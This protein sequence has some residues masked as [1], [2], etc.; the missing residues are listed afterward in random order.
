MA[1]DMIRIL[2]TGASG[3]IGA[4]LKQLLPEL[5]NLIAPDRNALDLTD[6]SALRSSI[7]K[8][9]PDLI[10]NAAAYTAVDR[11]EDEQEVARAVNAAAPAV[12][13]EEARAV[14]AAVVHYSTDYVFD[15]EK[16]GPYNESDVPR[17]LSTYGSSK[18]AGE[19]AIIAAGIPHLILRTSWIY[20]A[21]GVN[22]MRT[23]LRLA[24]E[25]EELRVVGDQFGAPTWCR[26]VA[27][28]TFSILRTLCASGRLDRNRFS[29]VSGLYHVTAGGETS[30][31]GFARA[32][33][34]EYA[35]REMFKETA[36]LKTQ[37]VIPIPSSEY[38]SRARRPRNSI[39]SNDKI[40]RTFG[41]AT[42]D[43]RVQL[44]TVMDEIAIE[45][46]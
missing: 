2:L 4:E 21:R 30:W 19:Q 29:T 1:G 17:P 32:I 38:P 18:L 25:R 9:K 44:R 14:Y 33:L 34:A 13:A 15:G 11:A 35:G 5:G 24:H 10:V 39:L 6:V 42:A 3:Q 41:V 36:K 23:I 8:I 40:A 46:K 16:S 45:F 27:L 12:I 31:H 37:R 7:R 22:F 43:W 26:S 28:A 20:G